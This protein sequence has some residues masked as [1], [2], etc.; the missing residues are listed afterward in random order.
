MAFKRLSLEQKED[1]DY[2]LVEKPL[3]KEEEYR[4]AVYLAVR[5]AVRGDPRPLVR[6]LLTNRPLDGQEVGCIQDYLDGKPKKPRGRSINP[7]LWGAEYEARRRLSKGRSIKRDVVVASVA[8]DFHVAFQT[9]SNYLKRSKKP[10]P[11]RSQ[12]KSQH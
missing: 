3:S 2:R 9:L 1:G 12:R 4:S 11:R 6:I 7:L 10:R 8:D 5:D